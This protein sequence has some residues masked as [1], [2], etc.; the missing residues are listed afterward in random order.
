[1]ASLVG[2]VQ[3]CERAWESDFPLKGTFNL[4]S[5][6]YCADR[7]RRRLEPIKLFGY[8]DTSSSGIWAIGL[9]TIPYTVMLPTGLGSRVYFRQRLWVG[10]Q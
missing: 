10:P 9:G 2:I 8:R 5:F 4:R 6:A 3:L 7:L 1:M